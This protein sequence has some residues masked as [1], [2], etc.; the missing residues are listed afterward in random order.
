MKIGKR[1]V[2]FLLVVFCTLV[3]VSGFDST[4]W[5][6]YLGNPQRTAYSMGKGPESPE[7]FW[8]VIIPG[9]FDT[10]PFVVDDKV[11]ILCKNDM[12]H[13]S[14]ATV[15]VID[16]VTGE[17]LQKFRPLIPEERLVFEI[18]PL[19]NKIMGMSFEGIYEIDLNS[20]KGTLVTE[21]PQMY[22]ST[23]SR[24]PVVLEVTIIFP[25]DPP[26][27][28]SRSS[29]DT[30]WNTG[31][32]LPDPDLHVYNL[33]ADE[34][35]VVFIV[36]KDGI[37]QLLA[38]DPST[39]MIKWM[40]DPIPLSLWLALGEDAVYSGGTD[41][42]AFDKEGSELWHFVPDQRIASNIVLGP[43]AV[44]VADYSNAVYKIGLDGTLVWK[45]EWEVSPWYYETHLLGVGDILYCIG[46]SGGPDS[47]TGCHITA[48]SMED[49]SHLWNQ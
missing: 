44:Y 2:I 29:M 26:V 5:T 32:I 15:V 34:T 45:T 12:Y 48:L 35:I 17:V 28:L 24:Y 25:T 30:V 13:I 21:I 11:F 18:F 7:I 6:D 38:A 40:S 36:G 3:N 14:T 8:K 27:C 43:D 31:D 10:P 22:Y 37:T 33:A 46:N 39:G 4:G 49:G 1:L 19:N 16:L 41:L 42:W 20:E 9:D 23:P 47:A